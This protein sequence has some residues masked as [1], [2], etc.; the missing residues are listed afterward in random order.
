MDEDAPRCGRGE[1]RSRVRLRKGS[2][3]T[4]RCVSERSSPNSGSPRS[5]PR[6]WRARRRRRA[7]PASPSFGDARCR[8][9][10]AAARSCG[11]RHPRPM[12]PRRRWVH[13]LGKVPDPFAPDAPRDRHLASHHEELEHLRDVAVVR[14]PAGR[15]G[16][17][18]RIGDV[19]RA[20]RARGREPVED[21]PAESVIVAKPVALLLVRRTS[22]SRGRGTGRGLASVAPPR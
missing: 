22:R 13:A 17:D 2:Q 5:S 3:G 21:V 7:R 11:V 4:R 18:R 15:P 10:Q 8:A 20:Q 16:H 1:L 14:P 6:P 12:A 9:R 19:A